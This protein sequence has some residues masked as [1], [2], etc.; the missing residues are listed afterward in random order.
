M[1]AH[2]RGDGVSVQRFRQ[3][4]VDEGTVWLG[5]A[6]KRL[7]NLTEIAS[8]AASGVGNAM[9][10]AGSGN[11]MRGMGVEAAPGASDGKGLSPPVTTA[12]GSPSWSASFTTLSR[13]SS[14]RLF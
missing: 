2:A 6:A 13:R 5:Q 11:G 3:Q 4:G 9:S 8:L 7:A 12:R 1:L 10:A 14:A